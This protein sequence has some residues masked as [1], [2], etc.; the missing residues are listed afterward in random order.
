[1]V[2]YEHLF[3]LR[4][5]LPLS[6]TCSYQQLS[7]ISTLVTAY[8]SVSSRRTALK[9]RFINCAEISSIE[10]WQ[11][12]LKTNTQLQLLVLMDWFPVKLANYLSLYTFE[13]SLLLLL[14]YLIQQN[15][16]K[17]ES[18]I[19][20]RC[21]LCDT[22]LSTALSGHSSELIRFSETIWTDFTTI[23][24]YKKSCGTC[25]SDTSGCKVVDWW[26]GFCWNNF[27]KCS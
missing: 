15:N 25:G 21:E 8:T 11:C 20:L 9:P 12:T 7:A 27:L 2:F 26:F 4:K 10:H 17:I 16:V 19:T 5:L 13:S 24:C 22:S 14:S 18:R 1:M 3:L 23:T 6:K